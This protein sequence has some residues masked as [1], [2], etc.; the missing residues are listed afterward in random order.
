M[1]DPV[2]LS[3]GNAGG[4]IVEGDGWPMGETREF[5]QHL[6][7]RDGKIAVFVGVA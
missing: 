2:T 4:E 1:I 6:Y 7:R 3:G 5:A